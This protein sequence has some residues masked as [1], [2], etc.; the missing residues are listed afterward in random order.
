MDQQPGAGSSDGSDTAAPGEQNYI[1]HQVAKN[2]KK[3]VPTTKSK[4]YI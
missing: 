1:R 3:T 4:S 2:I